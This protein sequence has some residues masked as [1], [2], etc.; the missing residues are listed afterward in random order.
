MAVVLATG[1]VVRGTDTELALAGTAATPI[2]S[3]LTVMETYEP[4]S[5]FTV[6]EFTPAKIWF[7]WLTLLAAGTLR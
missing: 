4:P 7:A 1:V 2:I 3:S 6:N 5:A